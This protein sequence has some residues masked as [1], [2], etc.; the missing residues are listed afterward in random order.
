MSSMAY[1]ISEV[2]E[3]S[4]VSAAAL[5]RFD[6]TGVVVPERSGGARHRSYSSSDLERLQRALTLQR[7]GM[8]SAEIK[9]ALDM[10]TDVRRD[11]LEGDATPDDVPVEP[12]ATRLL[13]R[14]GSL[15]RQGVAP[16]ERLPQLLVG[17]YIATVS[18][19]PEPA[20]ESVE[21]LADRCLLEPRRSALARID[22]GFPA[23][24]AKALHLYV[25]H[26]LTRVLQ[27]PLL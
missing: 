16:R 22:A 12:A 18:Y 27:R 3:L 25:D 20:L 7:F 24:L 5:R 1:T 9:R 23:W 11:A 13:E 10:R 21:G 26:R 15:C 8:T 14:L 19:S 2:S 17:E 4:G 6:R